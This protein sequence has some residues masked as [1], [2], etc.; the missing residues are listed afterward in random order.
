MIDG[1]QQVTSPRVIAKAGVEW[2]TPFVRGLTL[3]AAAQYYGKSFQ[4]AENTF[5]LPAYTTVDIGAKYALKL[6]KNQQ[7]TLRGAVE[8]VFNKNYWQIQRGRYDRS[9][10]VVGMPRTVWL[11]ADYEF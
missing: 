8:N 2:D 11:K 7:V 1:N 6:P 10:A 9:F 5:R 3:N 4:N